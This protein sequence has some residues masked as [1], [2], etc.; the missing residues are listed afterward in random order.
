MELGSLGITTCENWRRAQGT[1]LG[2]AIEPVETI[3]QVEATA[4]RDSL[5][6][7]LISESP[8]KVVLSGG[9]GGNDSILN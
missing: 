5:A 1:P 6:I 4:C 3:V 2:K 8:E 7:C 9:S